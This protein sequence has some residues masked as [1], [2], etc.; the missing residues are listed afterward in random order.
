MIRK[1]ESFRTFSYW[2]NHKILFIAFGFCLVINIA[3][4]NY[5]K[6]L[7][8]IDCSH[9]IIIFNF[10]DLYMLCISIPLTNITKN[11]NDS[12]FQL[13]DSLSDRKFWV[14]Q[15]LNAAEMYFS[16][17]IFIGC[18]CFVIP[19]LVACSWNEHIY[20]VQRHGAIED[21]DYK[22]LLSNRLLRGVRY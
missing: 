14:R 6:R 21:W 4:R 11:W 16:L 22:N 12:F 5:Y 8:W 1:R 15:L 18:K 19:P 20:N 2:I 13:S 7:Q 9:P 10:M 3:I 17:Y